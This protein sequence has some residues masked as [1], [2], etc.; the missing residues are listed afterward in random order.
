VEATAPVDLAYARRGRPGLANAITHSGHRSRL[1]RHPSPFPL[2][3]RLVH[4]GSGMTR[5]GSD[6]ATREKSNKEFERLKLRYG[7]IP[8]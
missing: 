1:Y 2:V 8:W 4:S 6:P 7:V 5:I 3:N